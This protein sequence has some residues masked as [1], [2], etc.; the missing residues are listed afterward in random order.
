[1]QYNQERIYKFISKLGMKQ[2]IN[3]LFEA[4]LTYHQL[5]LVLNEVFSINYITKNLNYRYFLSEDPNHSKH[6]RNL[7]LFKKRYGVGV[8]DK[9]TLNQLGIVSSLSHNRVNQVISR[10]ERKIF[11]EKPFEMKNTFNKSK[12]WNQKYATGFKKEIYYLCLEQ[13]CNKE[14]S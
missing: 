1:M 9:K 12:E 2:E 4:D 6:K 8:N 11:L 10:F 14:P 13:I 7:S 3:G 5:A